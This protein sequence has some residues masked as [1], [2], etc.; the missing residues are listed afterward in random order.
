[1]FKEEIISNTVKTK[2]KTKTN[3]AMDF[4]ISTIETI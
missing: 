2:T 3:P 1:M 4:N